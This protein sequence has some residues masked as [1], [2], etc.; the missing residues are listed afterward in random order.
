[1]GT[2]T[3][4]CIATTTTQH[5]ALTTIPDFMCLSG[6]S[7]L[8]F[9]Q[10]MSSLAEFVVGPQ[11]TARSVVLTALDR[12]EGFRYLTRV[13]RGGI[14]DSTN[15]KY[16]VRVLPAVPHQAMLHGV[17]YLASMAVDRLTARKPPLGPPSAPCITMQAWRRSWTPGTLRIPCCV[18]CPTT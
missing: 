16:S 11:P 10:A 2:Q 9:C 17:W 8:E 15:F 13:M 7:W 1:M 6:S 18:L 4:G 5:H 14:V 3:K 12:R